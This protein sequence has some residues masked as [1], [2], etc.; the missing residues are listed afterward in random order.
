MRGEEV[1]EV[2]EVGKNKGGEIRKREVIKNEV[3]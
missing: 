1:P 2:G 3:Q